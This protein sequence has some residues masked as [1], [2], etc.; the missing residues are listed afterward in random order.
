[1]IPLLYPEN[2]LIT[3]PLL[4]LKVFSALY[5]K[6]VKTN[7]MEEERRY[8]G[9]FAVFVNERGASAANKTIS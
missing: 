4:T 1:M 5:T 3:P 8:I 7:G 9:G 2:A 6:V